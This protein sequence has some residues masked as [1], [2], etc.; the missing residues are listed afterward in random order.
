MSVLFHGQVCTYCKH[1]HQHY[2]GYVPFPVDG[3]CY[4]QHRKKRSRP[5][6]IAQVNDF[7]RF[8]TI[9]SPSP[10]P[11]RDTQPDQSCAPR[12]REAF[13]VPVHHA[14][15]TDIFLIYNVSSQSFSSLVTSK[16]LNKISKSPYLK[17]SALSFF[18]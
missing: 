5:K 13:V 1:C 3:A 9:L 2:G 16:I 6:N 4:C 10:C 14:Q 17:G 15:G 11:V 8:I 7:F 18:L 12:R